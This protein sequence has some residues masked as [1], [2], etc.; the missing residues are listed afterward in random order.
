M[1]AALMMCEDVLYMQD[2]WKEGWK[3]LES[4]I[5][6]GDNIKLSVCL[7]NRTCHTK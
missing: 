7:T 4:H 3:L 5:E 1:N 2:G 6:K